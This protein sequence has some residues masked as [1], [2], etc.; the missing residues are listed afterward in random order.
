MRVLND[1]PP[2]GGMLFQTVEL[3]IH[4]F[5]LFNMLLQKY[6]PRLRNLK[7]VSVI[8]YRDKESNG[9]FYRANMILLLCSYD[10]SPG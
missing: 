7:A 2:F 6:D 1:L 9:P 5:L 4:S 3:V 8:I 10:S